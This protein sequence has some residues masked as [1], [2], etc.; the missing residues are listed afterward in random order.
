MRAQI[1]PD[2]TGFGKLNPLSCGIYPTTILSLIFFKE[3][4]YPPNI[5]ATGSDC[6][7]K[8]SRINITRFTKGGCCGSMAA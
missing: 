6:S 5:V 4:T 7:G 8:S 1:L 2:I 3:K